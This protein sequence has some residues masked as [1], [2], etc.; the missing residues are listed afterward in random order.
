MTLNKKDIIVIAIVLFLGS[1]I[2][3]LGTKQ[4][5]SGEIKEKDERVKNLIEKHSITLSVISIQDSLIEEMRL[6]RKSWE[7]NRDKINEAVH[8]GVLVI[9]D[10]TN[11]VVEE[12]DINEALSWVD[13]L[14]ISTE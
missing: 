6:E 4:Y 7:N 13:S 14:N 5:Y 8:G 10:L 1:I 9:G 3:F 12:S 11:V 2:G